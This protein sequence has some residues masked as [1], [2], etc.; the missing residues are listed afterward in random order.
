MTTS[1][2]VST[3]QHS[4]Y[5]EKELTMSCHKCKGT[6]VML[7]HGSKCWMPIN[8]RPC[9]LGCIPPPKTIGRISSFL[10]KMTTPQE[11]ACRGFLNDHREV[12]KDAP[13]STT[14]HQAWPGG[15]LGHI[16]E[17]MKLAVN[18]F[19]IFESHATET[20][21]FTLS[22]A[23]FVLF[24]HDIEKPWRLTGEPGSYYSRYHK[25]DQWEHQR[26][27]LRDNGF[28]EL[29]EPMHIQ[30]LQYVEGEKGDYTQG[31]RTMS[32]PM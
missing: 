11:L 20:L 18:L 23:L 2:T 24:L 3:S 4:D 31:K 27:L 10:H 9:P 28:W 13:G 30:A 6:G 7:T 5:A 22:D 26:R 15:Y 12:L 1:T 29:L 25:A 21:P 32:S 17:V 8:E 16:E 14:N 19:P